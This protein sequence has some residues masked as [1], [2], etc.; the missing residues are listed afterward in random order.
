MAGRGNAVGKSVLV[1]LSV[2][3]VAHEKCIACAAGHTRIAVEG[4]PR[5][6]NRI[7]K[8]FSWILQ[9]GSRKLDVPC[10]EKSRTI[11]SKLIFSHF[12]MVICGLADTCRDFLSAWNHECV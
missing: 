12:L 2:L 9:N 5:S 7:L 3:Q 6:T 10:T 1:S 8:G 11:A 4:F